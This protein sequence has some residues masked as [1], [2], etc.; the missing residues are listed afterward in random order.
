MVALY[1]TGDEFIIPNT[2]DEVG[3][4]LKRMSLIDF[5]SSPE[6]K[7][8]VEGLTKFAKDI[9]VAYSTVQRWLRQDQVQRLIAKKA[10]EMAM[11][12]TG[13]A[14]TYTELVKMAMN[15]QLD[16][17]VRANVLMHLS[18]MDL[19]RAELALKYMKKFDKDPKNVPISVEGVIE[20]VEAE[21]V[22]P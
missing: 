8:S 16:P 13:M 9:D 20:E 12:G 18:K 1:N 3:L 21:E 22:L 14:V 4:F 17:K 11:G 19:R 2:E 6:T 10:R 7:K 15:P 5:M